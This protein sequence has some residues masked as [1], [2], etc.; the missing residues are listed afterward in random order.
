MTIRNAVNMGLSK[1]WLRMDLDAVK[2]TRT[3]WEKSVNKTA[4][5]YT[6]DNG[7]VKLK[8]AHFVG[9]FIIWMSGLIF[10]I[11]SLVFELFDNLNTPITTLVL[12]LVRRQRF[13]IYNL[14]K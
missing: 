4:R 6:V 3:A 2:R 8:V 11:S 10:S 13:C 7:P 1:K 12:K 14:K 5:V 9:C